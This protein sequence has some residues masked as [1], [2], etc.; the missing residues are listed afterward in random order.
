MGNCAIYEEGITISRKFKNRNSEATQRLYSIIKKAIVL[1]QAGNDKERQDALSFMIKLYRPH[2]RKVATKV[3][4][5]LKGIV[6]YTDALQEA[7]ALFLWLLDKYNADISAFSYYIGVMLPQHLNR[8]AEKELFHGSVNILVDM[9]EYTIVDPV[10]N[11]KSTVEA[12]FNSYVFTKEYE[13]FIIERS[14]RQSRSKTVKI[15]CLSFFLGKS[16]CSQIAHD[17]GISYNAVYEIIGKIKDELREFLI[18][19]AF[20]TVDGAVGTDDG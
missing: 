14:Q 4:R 13:R 9:T 8:W 6:E 1:V 7:Y 5:D 12:H 15:V 16:S 19:S 18:K 3:Y 20:A 10:L 11:S 2:I 17:L